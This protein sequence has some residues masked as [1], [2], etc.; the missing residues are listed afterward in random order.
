MKYRFR[1]QMIPSKN[2]CMYEIQRDPSEIPFVVVVREHSLVGHKQLFHDLFSIGMW[3]EGRPETKSKDAIFCCKLWRFF[4]LHELYGDFE[5]FH[6]SLPQRGN[7]HPL[8]YRNTLK[9][10]SEIL[11]KDQDVICKIYDT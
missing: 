7:S 9:K 4:K 2:W 11:F 8:V 3:D 10:V 1:Y 5:P 6:L